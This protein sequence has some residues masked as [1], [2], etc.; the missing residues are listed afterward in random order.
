M[1]WINKDIET[2][3]LKVGVKTTI[4]F[5]T[6]TELPQIKTLSSSCGCSVPTYSKEKRELSVAFTP[7][8]VPQHLKTQGWYNSR[9]SIS[10][11]YMD[12]TK[13]V[14]TFKSKIIN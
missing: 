13:D 2:E 6:T 12:G 11:G 8:A 3:D 5:K 10:V 4:T 1:S 9:K 14:L 7:K